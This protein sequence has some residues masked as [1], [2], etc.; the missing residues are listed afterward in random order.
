MQTGTSSSNKGKSI[1]GIAEAESRGGIEEDSRG[2]ERG[3]G[4][5]GVS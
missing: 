2:L 4:G 5:G 3:S 1:G